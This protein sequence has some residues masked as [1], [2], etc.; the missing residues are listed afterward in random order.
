MTSKRRTLIVDDEHFV[1]KGLLHTIPWEQYGFSVVGE[2]E[3]GEKALA[4]LENN[5]VD[6]L[7][8]DLMMPKMS[9]FELMKKVKERYPGLFVV[10]LTCHQEF[11]YA[12]EAIQLGAIDYLVKTQIEDSQLD[13]ALGRII[14][15][16]EYEQ[17]KLKQAAPVHEKTASWE[18]VAVPF[19]E[20]EQPL[21]AMF[22]PIRMK[23]IGWR[24]AG[25]TYATPYAA[26]NE[27]AQRGWSQGWLLVVLEGERLPSRDE[28]EQYISR[29]L[30]YEADPKQQGVYTFKSVDPAAARDEQVPESIK[31]EWNT[32]RWISDEGKFAAW[33]RSVEELRPNSAALQS[34]MRS[35]LQA[36]RYVEGLSEFC[37][38]DF[39]LQKLC[40]WAEWRELLIRVREALR[41]DG[42]TAETCVSIH[43]ALVLMNGESG[44]SL[45]QEQIA[46][47]VALSRGYF[48]QCFRPITGASYHEMLTKLRIDLAAEWLTSTNDL[49]YTIAEQ[50]GFRDDKYFS[51][52]FRQHKGVSPSEY[53][54]QRAARKKNDSGR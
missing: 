27:W 22:D 9:G 50:T 48:A 16:V 38:N 8:T 45:S 36:W 3:N 31:K 2:A 11:H 13:E 39:T 34:L 5:E 30:F 21:P 26:A 49:I 54:H 32:L 41:N 15:R 10:V 1:R 12:T 24:L 33:S 29:D 40:C 14:N 25:H 7:F 47:R 23:G 28:W 52:V 17:E 42:F 20:E 6:V 51:K 43:R 53:R 19:G 37:L 44:M 35:T 18:L 4:F 46:Q